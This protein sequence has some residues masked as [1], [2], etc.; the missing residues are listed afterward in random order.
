M[1]KIDVS[2]LP[3]NKKIE[4]LNVI[5]SSKLN[6]YFANMMFTEKTLKSLE[7]A[8][9]TFAR[10]QLK[11]N[12]SSTRAQVFCPRKS[13][14]L[15]LLKPSTMYHAKRV[16]FLLSMLNSDDEHVKAVARGSFD[17]HMM[18]RKV[19]LTEPG[20]DGFGRYQV[21]EQRR[22]V[23]AG[24]AYWPR[25]TFVELNELCMRLGVMLDFDDN[26]DVYGVSIPA[27]DDGAVSLRYTDHQELYTAIK[28]LEI[29]KDISYFAGLQT[30]GRLQRETL[31]HADMSC[32][33]G[34]LVNASINDHLTRFIAKGRLQL[35][36]TNA[37]NNRY[38]PEF[39]SRE[40]PL[41]GFHS[42]TN[43]HALNTCRE[44]RGLY[45]ERH[46]RC[47][48]LVRK[49]LE[50]S[51]VTDFV[52]VFDNEAVSLDGQVAIDS[53]KPD[54]CLIDHRNSVAF[55][56]EV[57]NPFDSF[58][59]Q[60]YCTKFDKYMPL[61]IKLNDAGFFTKV[62]VL[63]IGSLGHVHKRV[64]SGLT[65]LGLSKRQSTGLARYMSISVMIGS[66]R[67]WARRRFREERQ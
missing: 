45:I 24:R 28:R 17:L 59:D 5:A 29:D 63:V 7:D 67:A 2:P 54:L 34:H 30:Q 27:S 21:N 31:P 16:S 40:C 22:I 3:V 25:S 56:V 61:C 46:D 50:K 38:F 15:G 49:E 42:D 8:I 14:G 51:V 57:A 4:A 37:V 1:N 53:G 20:E 55:I 10:Q 60:C 33:V 52:Q 26:A 18:K 35:I 62:I 65:L 43:S 23:K 48:E 6:F 11:F 44:L 32:S 66:R 39:Y 41:C 9:V 58:L 64:V 13:G 19:A 47:V 36:E 12:T